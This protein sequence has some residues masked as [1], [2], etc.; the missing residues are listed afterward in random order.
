[1][2]GC[3][4]SS[5]AREPS[6]ERSGGAGGPSRR[7]RT[8]QSPPSSLLVSLSGQAAVA[9]VPLSM[10]PSTARHSAPLAAAGALRLARLAASV[11]ATRSLV[12]PRPPRPAPPATHTHHHPPAEP[13]TTLHHPPSTQLEAPTRPPQPNH[14][15]PPLVTRPPRA[16]DTVSH[17]IVDSQSPPAEPPLPLAADTAAAAAAAADTANSAP[18]PS[19]PRPRPR[20]PAAE[21]QQPAL[22]VEHPDV[23]P[24]TPA[25]RPAP[26]HPDLDPGTASPLSVRLHLAHRPGPRRDQPWARR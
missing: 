1:M 19:R 15:P 17:H 16:H 6:E 7:S 14:I 21:L 23:P 9:S 20:A 5:C 3:G 22:V 13:A 26:A 18:P 2:A 11:H 25:D 24:P 12:H 4:E 8:E 10:H